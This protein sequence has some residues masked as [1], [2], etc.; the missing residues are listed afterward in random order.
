MKEERKVGSDHSSKPLSEVPVPGVRAIE[1]CH[2]MEDV[3]LDEVELN[4]R[5]L[6]HNQAQ[7]QFTL[8]TGVTVSEVC[9]LLVEHTVNPCGDQHSQNPG[10]EKTII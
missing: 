10:G 5:P 7:L 3:K 6:E 9:Y 4:Q 8:N 2:S 1:I